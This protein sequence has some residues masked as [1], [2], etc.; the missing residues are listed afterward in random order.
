MKIP[1]SGSKWFLPM[2]YTIMGVIFI[3]S[4]FLS[5]EVQA[6]DENGDRFCLAQNIYFEAGNQPFIG[7][8]AVANVTLNRVNDLQFPNT[9][10][11]VVYQ[12][13][14]Y[15]KSWTGEIIPKRGMCQFSWYCDGKS[16]EPKD[17][18]TWIESIRIADMALQSSNFDVT[19]GALWYHADY[20][21][22]YWADH[23]EYV[24]TIENH[25]FYK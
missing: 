6:F 20:I 14:A 8:F 2:H 23:L 7:R 18:V 21:H 24:V 12:S 15:K 3:L 1:D 9:V 5:R 19:E 17:S 13:A 4:L 11:E 25:I 22:P 16:D 10:C